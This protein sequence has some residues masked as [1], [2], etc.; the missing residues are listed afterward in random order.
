MLPRAV[1]FATARLLSLFAVYDV[2]QVT[3]LL[4]SVL[5]YILPLYNKVGLSE[6]TYLLLLQLLL[7][8]VNLVDIV[9]MQLLQLFLCL[10]HAH[11]HTNELSTLCSE[12]KTPTHI[13]FH[14]SMSY[15]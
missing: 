9:I 7:Q 11:T 1:S 3:T 5:N 10:T 4:T 13:F 12:K 15:V 8:I 2:S 6:K 14:I